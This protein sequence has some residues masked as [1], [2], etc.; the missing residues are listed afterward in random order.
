MR[1]QVVGA[2]KQTLK[3]AKGFT[4]TEL[5]VVVAV[6]AIL[7]SVALPAMDDY[8]VNNRLAGS[9]E[10][11][12]SHF[13]LAR[14]TALARNENIFVR[15]GNTGTTNWCL[16][17]SDDNAC[18]CTTGTSCTLQDSGGTQVMVV[19]ILR[20]ADF[21]DI[22]LSTTFTDNDTGLSMPRGTALES[23]RVTLT[24]GASGDTT[25]VQVNVLGRVKIC[26][27]SLDQYGGC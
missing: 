20:G 26:S 3:R 9:T 7:V 19:P 11:V 12:Y 17:I 18:D 1:M 22:S 10:A 4:L 25:Q 24:S 8:L 13:Q 15:F 16:A 21:Q 27:N 2:Y 5:L 23:G 14:S 6:V